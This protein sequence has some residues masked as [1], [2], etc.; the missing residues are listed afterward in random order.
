MFLTT[1]C[2]AYVLSKKQPA[3]PGRVLIWI[4]GLHPVLAAGWICI[5]K[6]RSLITSLGM[7]EDTILGHRGCPIAISVIHTSWVMKSFFE[8]LPDERGGGRRRRRPGYTYRICCGSIPA[9]LMKARARP[10]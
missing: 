9:A 4:R 1:T 6:L 10:R 7:T 8:N 2:Y 3:G 5:P